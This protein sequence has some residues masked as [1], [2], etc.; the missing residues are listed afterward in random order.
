MAAKENEN[1]VPED[2]EK[3]GDDEAGE[4]DKVISWELLHFRGLYAKLAHQTAR[5]RPL[6][7]SKWAFF[8]GNSML[9]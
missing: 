3:K 4:D 9:P 2:E 6:S 5:L 8:G 1:V 7:V